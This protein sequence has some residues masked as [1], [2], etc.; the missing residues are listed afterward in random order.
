MKLKNLASA[1]TLLYAGIAQATCFTVYKADGTLIQETS[2]SPVD[3]TLQIGDAVVAKF[4]TGSSMTVSESG[5]SCKDR[6]VPVAGAPKSLAEIVRAEEEKKMAIKAPA[7]EVAP[8]LVVAKKEAAKATVVKDDPMR[9]TLHEEPAKN[10][11]A[12]ED[13]GKT[14]LAREDGAKTVMVKQDGTTSVVETRQGTVLKMK[15]AKKK[16]TP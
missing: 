14:A 16:E 5:Y 1:A 10:A 13:G 11:A 6:G 15:P 12:K 9:A 2:T 8:K 7:A 3:L 4:G